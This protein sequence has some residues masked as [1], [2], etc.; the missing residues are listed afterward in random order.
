MARQRRVEEATQGTSERGR[1]ETP[2][3]ICRPKIPPKPELEIQVTPEDI[4][5]VAVREGVH[6]IIQ[7][8]IPHGDKEAESM[9]EEMLEVPNLMMEDKDI[10]PATEGAT[11]PRETK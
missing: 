7:A 6:K 9:D 10:R 11:R 4:E 8:E 2:R 5:E 1:E 3:I